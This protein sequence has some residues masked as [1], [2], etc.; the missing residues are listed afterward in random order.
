MRILSLRAENFQRLAVVEIVP[1]GAV[2]QITGANESGKSSVLDAVWVALAG[3]KAARAVP[4]RRGQESA[5]IQLDLGE[6][7]VTR[8]FA[9]GG[10]STLVLEAENGARFPSPQSMLDKVI[11]SLG[12]DPL[13]FS[14]MTPVK[15]A[16]TLRELVKLDVGAFDGRITRAY[17]KRTAVNHR[18]REL[19]ARADQMEREID[20]KATVVLIDTTALLDKMEQASEH[21]AAIETEKRRRAD[22]EDGLATMRSVLVEIDTEVAR[23]QRRRGLL[24]ADIARVEEGLHREA[25]P[26]AIDVSAIRRELQDAQEINTRREKEKAVRETRER[27]VDQLT[28]ARVDAD[29]FTAEID[30][31]AKE[32][33]DAIA[34]VKFPIEGLSLDENGVVTFD[35]LPFEMA[36][37]ARQL[38]VSVALAMAMN[39]RLRVLHI[40]DG[41]LLDENAL[42]TIAAMAEAEDYQVWL[43]VVRN[44]AGPCG[45]FLSEGEVV[46]VDGKPVEQPQGVAVS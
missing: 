34:A 20:P 37:S 7:K 41:S 22:E 35:G 25:L 45:I 18:V 2:V 8:R 26:E 23:L 3:K 31:A 42:A 16:E 44:D 14:R 46:A 33:L 32:K 12:F 1:N 5:T 13:A 28:A 36:S 30:Q 15:Q 38:Q 10:D 17:E 11:G 40:R 24:V 27:V 6:V 39:P 9:K 4:I 21:N 29:N 19:T 43:E